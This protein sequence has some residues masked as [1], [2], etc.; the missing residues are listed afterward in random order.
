[1]RKNPVARA[2]FKIGRMVHRL[3]MSVQEDL[4]SS[5]AAF[6]FQQRHDIAC[7][8]IAEKLAQCFLVI[9]NF[10]FGN[11][12]KKILRSISGQRRLAEMW[13]RGNK[14][15]WSAMDIGK[16]AAASAGDE[17]FLPNLVRV[18]QHSNPLPMLPSLNRAHQPSRAGTENEDIENIGHCGGAEA[19]N[20]SIM[21]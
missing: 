20:F 17:D 7:R 8:S 4:H 19:D 5:L 3:H 16:V 15:F 11:Q 12:C 13:I 21:P 9:R 14:V 1:T 2:D 10:V 18:I 6:F